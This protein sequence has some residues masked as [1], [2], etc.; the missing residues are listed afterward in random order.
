MIFEARAS[1]CRGVWGVA[2][3]LD[4]TT[5]DDL[6]VFE[7]EKCALILFGDD[8]RRFEGVDV[9]C[10]C[11]AEEF[12]L[13][14]GLSFSSFPRTNVSRRFALVCMPVSDAVHIVNV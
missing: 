4:L 12:G 10:G 3:G 14:N 9:G 11:V 13:K 2:S 6:V 5:V 1:R 8:V 7:T